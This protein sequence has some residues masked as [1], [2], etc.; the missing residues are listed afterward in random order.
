MQD[1]AGYKIET[2]ATENIILQKIEYL[3]SLMEN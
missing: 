1:E 3:M 2:G